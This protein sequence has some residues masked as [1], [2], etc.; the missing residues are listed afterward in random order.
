MYKRQALNIR[1]TAV[2]SLLIQ[3]PLNVDLS[4]IEWMETCDQL[5]LLKDVKVFVVNGPHAASAFLGYYK[6]YETINE[7]SSDE[8][9][10]VYKRQV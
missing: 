6:G 5:E 3:Q 7:I 2:L 8:E 4:A 10:D 1:T 9:G